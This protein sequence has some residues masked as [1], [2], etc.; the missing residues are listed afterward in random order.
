MKKLK[1]E[2]ID[3][4]RRELIIRLY[5]VN[6]ISYADIGRIFKLSRQRVKQIIDYEKERRRNESEKRN[7]NWN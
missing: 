3:K 4:I 6:S 2:T 5:E 7:S 1:Q